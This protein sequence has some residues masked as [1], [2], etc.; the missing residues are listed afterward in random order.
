[1]YICIQVFVSK[2]LLDNNIDN[3]LTIK[4]NA[5]VTLTKYRDGSVL[6][7]FFTQFS[8]LTDLHLTVGIFSVAWLTQFQ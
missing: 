4:L 5:A 3:L 7:T 1:M 6:V 8:D 2:Y